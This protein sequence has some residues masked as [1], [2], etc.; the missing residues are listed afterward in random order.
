LQ[1][2]SIESNSGSDL[3]AK[4]DKKEIDSSS[5]DEENK[6]EIVANFSVVK[7]TKKKRKKSKLSK[8]KQ[9]EKLDAGKDDIEESLKLVDQIFNDVDS[10]PKTSQEIDVKKISNPL[11]AVHRHLNP[12]NELKR[13]FGS[14]VI[15][16]QLL[17]K[18]R[19]RYRLESKQLKGWTLIAPKK[20]LKE[21]PP[22]S[23][24]L[25]AT[26]EHNIRYFKFV[27]SKA[28]QSAQFQFLEA[29]DSYNPELLVNLHKLYPYHIDTILQLS[30][31]YKMTEETQMAAEFIGKPS[32]KDEIK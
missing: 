15:Q 21:K 9:Q 22:F 25:I 18:E 5:H 19:R 7:K 8:N 13:I 17:S 20:I 4:E 23:M 32:F 1:L 12:E 27:H 28:Y 2:N 29:I 31:F 30:N 16:T 11:S 6:A 3:E 14:K 26:D 10:Q 24:E